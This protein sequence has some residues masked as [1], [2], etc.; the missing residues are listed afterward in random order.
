MQ[1]IYSILALLWAG[2][3]CVH[4]QHTLSGSV[5]AGQNKPLDGAHIHIGQ[6]QVITGPDGYYEVHKVDTGQQ[7]VII[8]YIGYKTLDTLLNVQG[9]L[10]LDAIL[11]PESR[12]LA[13]VVLNDSTAAKT[14]ARAKKLSTVTLEKYSAGSLGDA[15]KEIPGVYALKTGSTVVKPVINGLHSSRVPVI[16]NNVRLEDQQWGTEHAPNLDLNSAGR[17]SV[18]KGANALQYSGDA[19]GGLV[20]TEPITIPQDTLYGRTLLNFASNGRGSSISSSLHKGAEQGWAW[21]VSGTLKYFGDRHSPDYILSNT[22]NTENNFAGDIKFMGSSYDIS[23]YYS[24][25]DATIGIAKATHIGN[26]ADLVRAINSGRPSVIEPFTYGIETPRQE[27]QHHLAKANFNKQLG[28]SSTLAV[29]YAFQ[30]NHRQEYDMR[31]GQY[32]GT[33]ALDLTL[34]THSLQADW[35]VE[36]GKLV[37]KGGVSAAIQDNTADP[38]TGVRPLIPNYDKYD[39]GAYGIASYA[40][41]DGLTAEGGLRYDF[42]HVDASKFYQK[43]RWASLSYVDAFDHFITADHSTQWLTNPKFT[44]HNISGSLGIRKQLGTRYELLANAG[45]T[46]RNPN[47]SELFSDGLHHSNGTIELGSLFITKEKAMKLSGTLVKNDGDFTFEATPYINSIKDFIY[48]EPTGIEYT[49]RGAF[50]VYN[51]RQTDALLAGLDLQ[52]AWDISNQ[53]Q[54]RSGLA[55]LYGQDVQSDKPL[56]DMPPLNMTNT[57][58]Y[59]NAEWHSL[60]LELRSEAV[61]GQERYP[62]NNFYTDVTHHGVIVPELVDI[63]TPPAGYHLLHFNSGITFS[64]FKNGCATIGLAIYNILNTPYRDYLNRQRSYTDDL[65]RNMQLQVKFIY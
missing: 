39:A 65:G 1:F 44:Y 46:M 9:D 18:I 21:N 26:V 58:R 49:I 56:I 60:F 25:Y 55:Y 37:L 13:A 32:A 23:A 41:N 48:L 10:R 43:T 63:S 54:Y 19:I 8:S 15:L 64:T 57:V 20:L 28:E 3:L 27:V 59:S 53:W 17:V 11:K 34:A 31:R 7:R 2:N 33:P 16:A 12:Q 29:Q 61:F 36:T 30:L 50:P 4:A 62:H 14:T 45:L 38:D 5:S 22:G 51:Y 52:A 24:F 35:K 40:I 6:L 42:S 47:P